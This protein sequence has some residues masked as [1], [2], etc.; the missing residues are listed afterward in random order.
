MLQVPSLHLPESLPHSEAIHSFG[1]NLHSYEPV[2]WELQY[3][4]C[5][6]LERVPDGLLIERYK[7]ILRN[8]RALI[9]RERD[10]IP[11]QSFLSSWYWFCKEHQTRLEFS[12]REV[13]LPVASPLGIALT[14]RAWGSCPAEAPERRK[15]SVPL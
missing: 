1:N 6:Y 8:M 10:I 4:V 13:S 11:I 14:M 15:Y 7:D 2:F 12:L 5:R 9:S 3:K